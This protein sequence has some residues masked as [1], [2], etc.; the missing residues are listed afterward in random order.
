MYVRFHILRSDLKIR[1][2]KINSHW[3]HAYE[4]FVQLQMFGG[5]Q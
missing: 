2:T 5:V 3:L 4:S 1:S